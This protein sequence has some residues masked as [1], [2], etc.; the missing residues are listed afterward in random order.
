MCFYT[1]H[2]DSS[3]YSDRTC[4]ASNAAVFEIGRMIS[5][6]QC[7]LGRTA[8]G[9]TTHALAREAQ[10]SANTVSKFEAGKVKPNPSTVQVIKLA[11]ERHGVIFIDN[12]VG[13]GV[14]LRREK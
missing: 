7:K 14:K 11:L 2:L 12:G 6:L 13:E 8:L 10:V 9:W 1:R 5:P 3:N 4:I